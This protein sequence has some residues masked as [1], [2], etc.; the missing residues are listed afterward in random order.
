M[1]GDVKIVDPMEF[2]YYSPEQM[3]DPY[4]MYRDLRSKCPVAH[5]RHHGGFA[6]ASTYDES[7]SI[8]SDFK[9]YSSNN[10]IGLPA[11]PIRLF[12][13]DV[14]P[15]E[16]VRFR[17]ILN[18]H[19]TPE[20]AEKLRPQVERLVDQLIDGFIETGHAELGDDMV[21][22]TLP[23]TLLPVLG[24]PL[25]DLPKFAGWVETTM[26]RRVSD[27]E[28]VVRAAALIHEYV[29]GIVA[30]RRANQPGPH[31]V[32]NSLL[33]QPFDGRALDDDEIARTL[34]IIINGA[35]DTTTVGV[36]EALLHL[37]RHPQDAERLRSGEVPYPVAIEELLRAYCPVTVMGRTVMNDGELR[38]EPVKAGE[39]IMA[40]PGAANRDPARFEDPDRVILDRADNEHLSFG[41]GAHICLGRHI[42]RMEI[43]VFL[44]AVLTRMP[45]FRTPEGFEPEFD[46]FSGRAMKHLPVVFTPGRRLG[47]SA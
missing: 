14:D 43:E 31:D 17:R 47:G 13:V 9:N 15:P 32:L 40:M 16:Q 19:F 18:P 44:R 41:N 22:P 35:L 29:T 37:S 5:S 45:D 7:K 46:I 2:D 27:P 34:M 20:A 26:R 10:G 8:L 39:F 24:I 23:A 21:R 3:Y 25:E 4:P 42:A 11:R 28:G 30:G 12:P 6:F 33:T 38:G 36:L 1:A